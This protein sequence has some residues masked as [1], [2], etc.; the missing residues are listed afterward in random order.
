[1]KLIRIQ[2]HDKINRKL[3]DKLQKKTWGEVLHEDITYFLRESKNPLNGYPIW[4]QIMDSI[5]SEHETSWQ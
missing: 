4:D 3:R 1:M 2:T 5:K